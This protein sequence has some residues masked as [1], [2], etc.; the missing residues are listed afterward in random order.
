MIR[1]MIWRFIAA[2]RRKEN[3][4]KS[5]KIK[6]CRMRLRYSRQIGIYIR[7]WIRKM[8]SHHIFFSRHSL[9]IL[10]KSIINHWRAMECRQITIFSQF[11][12]SLSKIDLS[13][14]N[15]DWLIDTLLV[16]RSGLIKENTLVVFHHYGFH[17]FSSFLK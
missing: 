13:L 16:S 7:W 3:L 12:N 8:F 2:I 14:I 9:K 1:S 15:N 11:F 17:L 6:I 10:K 4:D 5:V